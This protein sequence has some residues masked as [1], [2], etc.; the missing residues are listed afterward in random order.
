MVRQT[1]TLRVETPPAIDSSHRKEPRIKRERRHS[2]EKRT[3]FDYITHTSE[4]REG[5]T[6]FGFGDVVEHIT[7]QGLGESYIRWAQQRLFGPHDISQGLPTHIGE[8]SLPR[9]LQ[10]EMS[11]VRVD[12]LSMNA[13]YGHLRPAELFA[14]TLQVLG[15]K[16]RSF[17]FGGPQDIIPRAQF[18]PFKGFNYDRLFR[19]IAGGWEEKSL[20]DAHLQGMIDTLPQARKEGPFYTGISR[21]IALF[22]EP[23]GLLKSMAKGHPLKAIEKAVAD[24]Y[25]VKDTDT[26]EALAQ[27]ARV[28]RRAFGGMMRRTLAS[29]PKDNGTHH[30][31]LSTYPLL[32]R[33][34]GEIQRHSPHIFPFSSFHFGPDVDQPLVAW[35]NGQ[36][37][38][39]ERPETAHKWAHRLGLPYP[40]IAPYTQVVNGYVAPSSVFLRDSLNHQRREALD[41]GTPLTVVA[42]AS[43]IAPTQLGSFVSFLEGAEHQMKGGKMRMVI[44]CGA[45]EGGGNLVYKRLQK[46]VETHGLED[47]V[48][49]HLA[50]DPKAAVDFFEAVSWAPVPMALLV[51]G[52]EVTRIAQALNIPVIPTGIVG[53]HE[54]GNFLATL[55]DSPHMLTFPPTV[56]PQLQQEARRILPDHPI[57]DYFMH[58][59]PGFLATLYAMISQRTAPNMDTLLS[60]ISDTIRSGTSPSSDPSAMLHMVER[61][62]QESQAK[63]QDRA[64][65]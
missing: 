1:E 34:I 53:D 14:H 61:M 62:I 65:Q 47:Y 21:G 43:G 9:M 40:E 6:R 31:V 5:L 2:P 32:A 12:V 10:T 59:D 44:Q 54:L 13:G 57:A 16:T 8:V 39:V 26:P 29:E 7:P 27:Q 20:R 35:V 23:I 30:V 49:L 33:L 17:F 58:M 37:N 38:F 36:T 3:P 41:D 28:M 63:Q 64:S 45:E 52:A 15:G 22:R 48:V 56:G 11:H 50:E 60:M 42:L 4:V 46:V 24:V 55:E 18:G 19:A 51:K 25:A